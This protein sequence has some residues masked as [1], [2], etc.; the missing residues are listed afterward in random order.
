MEEEGRNFDT[1]Q[2]AKLLSLTDNETRL[3]L[4]I[5]LCEEERSVNELSDHLG[6][7]PARASYYLGQLRRA[8]VVL[9][10]R[11]GHTVRYICDDENVLRM[12]DTLSKL[13]WR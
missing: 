6:L 12:L 5:A 7:L 9:R 8:R 13:A 11:C 10:R 1:I 2:A 3:R 4:L